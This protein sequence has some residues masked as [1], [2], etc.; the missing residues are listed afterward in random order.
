MQRPF[1]SKKCTT[2]RNSR[3]CASALPRV[4][5]SRGGGLGECQS[6]SE[7][8]G[9]D[10]QVVRVEGMVRIRFFKQFMNRPFHSCVLSVLAWIESEA[11]ADLVLIETSLLF[12]CKCKLVSIR[13][14]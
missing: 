14:A 8:V 13:T 7:G 1:T 11:E 6:F 2:V 9:G 4:R 12:L 3:S 5:F 10:Y